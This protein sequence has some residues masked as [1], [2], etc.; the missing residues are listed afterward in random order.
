MDFAVV[1]VFFIG[2]QI[3]QGQGASYNSSMFAN[4]LYRSHLNPGEKIL[5][6]AHVHPFTVYKQFLKYFSFGIA[7]PGLFYLM[8]PPFWMVW[9]GW[10]GIGAIYMIFFFLDW[11]Y[12]ALLVTNQSLMDLQ[13]EGIW[14]RSSTRIEYHTIEGVSYELKGFWSVI[15]NY[16][17]I[18]IERLGVGQPVGLNAVSFPKTVE[19]EILEAQNEFM[20]NKSFR[21]HQSLKDLL[22]NMMK[23]Y[24]VFK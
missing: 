20:R 6:I 8:M 22:A 3:D 23:D 11:Y 12:D 5:Y 24:S 13:W 1:R 9:A 18:Q 2:S 10:A 4:I 15:M 19:R 16:G 17:D 14:N 21:D 7:L